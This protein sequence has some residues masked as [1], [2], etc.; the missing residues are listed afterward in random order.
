MRHG[1]GM[2]SAVGECVG[3]KEYKCASSCACLSQPSA[4]SSLD[5]SASAFPGLVPSTFRIIRVIGV[6]GGGGGGSL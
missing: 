2:A 6:G 4:V 3:R 1:L 5:L